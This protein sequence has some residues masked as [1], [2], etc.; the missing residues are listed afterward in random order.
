MAGNIHNINSFSGGAMAVL[1][2][3]ILSISP[4]FTQM[5]IFSKFILLLFGIAL[6]I[7]GV[8]N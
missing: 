1:A 5:G 8:K 7:F 3:I 4:W 2:G 6:I